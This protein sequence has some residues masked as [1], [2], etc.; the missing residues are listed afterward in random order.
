MMLNTDLC[1]LLRLCCPGLRHTGVMSSIAP[2]TLLPLRLLLSRALQPL[3]SHVWEWVHTTRPPT[4][5][6]TLLQGPPPL[7][8]AEAA[9]EPYP[10]SLPHFLSGVERMYRVAG[11]QLRLLAALCPRIGP[12]S[13]RLQL[14]AQAEAAEAR[15]LVQRPPDAAGVAAVAPGAQDG[16]SKQDAGQ[17]G[18]GLMLAAAFSDGM[19]QGLGACGA[20]GLLQQPGASDKSD[21]EGGYQLEF[22]LSRLQQLSRASER[23][24]ELREA[25]LDRC[26][27]LLAPAPVVAS[28]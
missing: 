23:W 6:F 28:S 2:T 17:D 20:G 26:D 4:R 9:S 24:T 3:T 10:A 22:E 27:V 25:E 14:I 5:G 1:R 19:L 7:L 8:T 16:S 11:R 12:L 13:E 15:Q 21:S 18:G